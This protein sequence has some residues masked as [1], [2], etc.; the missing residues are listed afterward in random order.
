[1]YPPTSN[2]VRN[3]S[4]PMANEITGGTLRLNIDE[5]QRTVPS[6]PSAITKSMFVWHS[7]QSSSDAHVLVCGIASSSC[8]TG[9]RY[10]ARR[11]SRM[12]QCVKRTSVCVTSVSFGF[13]IMSTLLGGSSHMNWTL[14][15]ARCCVRILRFM[16]VKTSHCSSE[17]W[18][19]RNGE[20]VMLNVSSDD[21][22]DDDDDE[23]LSIVSSFTM[24]SPGEPHVSAMRMS[25]ELVRRR[26]FFFVSAVEALE[27]TDRERERVR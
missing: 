23:S 19:S 17:H 5:T 21:V 20:R 2:G 26:I 10:T 24:P 11:F 1:M 13:L 3:P 22:D 15:R 6:P 8:T 18:S 27:A 14:F 16:G 25:S 4:E 12:S 7:S 9:S